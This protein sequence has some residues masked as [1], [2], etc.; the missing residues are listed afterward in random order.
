[1]SSIVH[2]GDDWYGIAV[3][4]VADADGRV[5]AVGGNECAGVDWLEA[6]RGR[7]RSELGVPENCRRSGELASDAK[8]GG[9]ARDVGG[10]GW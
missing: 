6:A 8:R 1:M 3:A 5:G 7:S 9:G 2:G 4:E 10:W